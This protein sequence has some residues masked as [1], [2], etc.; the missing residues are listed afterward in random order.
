MVSMDFDKLK[1]AFFNIIKNAMESIPDKGS[2]FLTAEPKARQWMSIQIV[3][4]G[5]GLSPEEIEQI[6]DPDYTTK[7]KGLGLGLPLAFEIIRGHGGQVEVRSVP[8]E[9]ST[10]EILLP[11]AVAQN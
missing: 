4:T 10:F 3:D 8:G 6:F 9:G 2:I 7:E 5:R 11:A 1:Q